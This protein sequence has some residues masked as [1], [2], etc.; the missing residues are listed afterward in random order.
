MSE[1]LHLFGVQ[2]SSDPAAIF[3]WLSREM[4]AY[5]NLDYEA[6]GLMGTATAATP[7]EVLR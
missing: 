2:V 5:G 7:E 3:E 6:I 1:L 4:P